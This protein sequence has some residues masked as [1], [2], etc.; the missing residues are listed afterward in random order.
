MGA[1]RRYLNK[2]KCVDTWHA[3]EGHLSFLSDPNMTGDMC[4][5]WLQ[6]ADEM[7]IYANLFILVTLVDMAYFCT[8]YT[9]I[10]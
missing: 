7:V 5:G 2:Y 10:I 8:F 9:T 4:W 6:Y 3:N 1:M